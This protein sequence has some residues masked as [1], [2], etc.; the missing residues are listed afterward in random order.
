M[1]RWSRGSSPRRPQTAVRLAGLLRRGRGVPSMSPARSFVICRRA[2]NHRAGPRRAARF[3]STPRISR[4]NGNGMS[5]GS[6]SALTSGRCSGSMTC[7]RSKMLGEFAQQLD[8]ELVTFEALDG[9]G[10]GVY[11]TNVMMALGA[12]FAV[13]CGPAIAE[14]STA[15]RSIHACARP[16][17]RSSRFRAPRCTRSRATSWSSRRPAR[18]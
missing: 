14:L 13:V 11:H 6:T 7:S 2:R 10:R 18:T 5:P 9:A 1:R 4:L 8:Y 15:T 3:I 16:G 17:A 12:Q